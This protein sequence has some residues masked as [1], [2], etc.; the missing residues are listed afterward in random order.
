MHGAAHDL[1]RFV[2]HHV[3]PC[4]HYLCKMDNQKQNTGG[5]VGVPT[6]RTHMPIPRLISTIDARESPSVGRAQFT[7]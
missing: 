7:W 1:L 2:R 3:V 5:R 4:T 6:Y